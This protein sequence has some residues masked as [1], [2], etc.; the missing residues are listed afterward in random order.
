PD[1]QLRTGPDEPATGVQERRP[2]PPPPQ[3]PQHLDPRERPVRLQ[4]RL[5]GQHHL[6]EPPRPDRLPPPPTPGPPRLETGWLRGPAG[7][8][9]SRAGAAPAAGGR[10]RVPA[11]AGHRPGDRP[12]AGPASGPG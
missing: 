8:I 6:V 10:G 11:A 12:G 5:P 9:R 7:A 2:A 3:P 4:R 1:Q